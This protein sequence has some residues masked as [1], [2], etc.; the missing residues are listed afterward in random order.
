[1]FSSLRIRVSCL[2]I[3][4]FFWGSFLLFG[5]VVLVL[6]Y[7]LENKVFVLDFFFVGSL[8]FSSICLGIRVS[9]L[10]IFGGEG[11]SKKWW[12]LVL[13][14]MLE[15]KVFVLDFFG[16]VAIVLKN[17]NKGLVLENIFFPGGFFFFNGGVLFSSM[18]IWVSCF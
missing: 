2:R 11:S 1:M 10:R 16:G 9:C 14:H 18:R 15:N 12:G 6:K 7:M 13:K 8:L 3:F 17:E 4:F 5:R